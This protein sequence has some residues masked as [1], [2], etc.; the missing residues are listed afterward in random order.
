[1]F[2]RYLAQ[3]LREA[4]R[5]RP[6]ILL[7]GGRQVGKST[8]A[9][10]LV[11]E[12]LLD[13][14]LTLDDLTLLAAAT[15][16]PQGFLAGLQGPVVLDEI[17][18]AP[19]L[20]LPLKAWVDRDRRPGRFLLT[21]SANLLA[22]P[23]AAGFL[24]GR[25]AL[26]TLWPLS[27]GEIEGRREGFLSALFAE[28]LPPVQGEGR[29]PLDRLLRGGY[30]EAVLLSPE[31]RG[32]WF[33]DYLVTLLAREV[34]ELSQIE[35]VA[36]LPRLYRLL[37][38]RPMDLLNWAELGRTLGLAA[39]TLKRYFALLE[40]LYLV[41]TLPP[42]Q[43]NLG[44]RLVKSPKLLPTDTGL[45]LHTLG[46]DEKRLEADRTLLGGFLEAFVAMELLKQLGYAP[47]SAQLFHYR[48]HTG[49]EVDLVLEGPGGRVVG[50][51]VKA[52]GSVHPKDLHGL[53]ALAQA[54]GPRFHRGVVLYLGREAV[55]FGPRL[56]ALPLE[57]LWRL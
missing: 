48:S 33:R 2:P 56:H 52:R 26:F 53:K 30:P 40:A 46:L 57:A 41:H 7:L 49:E 5:A 16:D 45:A 15:E 38:S 42:W 50:L 13:R 37:A 17:Q 25:V 32:A 34:R 47:F 28:E 36:E 43:A 6:V 18:R 24:V 55:P 9:Q 39:T 51:E 31:Q 1:M 11:A 21:G 20:L 3:P 29:L 8:L 10:A 44:K 12:G 22:L 23:K 35:R 4:L 19:G 14:Y 54:L 27:Q